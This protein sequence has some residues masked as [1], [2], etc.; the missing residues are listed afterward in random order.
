MSTAAEMQLRWDAA[1]TRIE[2]VRE[3]VYTCFVHPALTWSVLRMLAQG[4]GSP[5][6]RHTRAGSA[7]KRKAARMA[8]W[9]PVRPPKLE[10][11]A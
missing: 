1:D 10:I 4:R 5:I 2:A 6:R 7:R 9:H 8:S 11:T 3:R